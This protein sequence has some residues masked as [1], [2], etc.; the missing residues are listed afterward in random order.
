M[1]T[2]TATEFRPVGP[3]G[4]ILNVV[5]LNLANPWTTIVLPWIVLGLIFLLN[6]ILWWIILSSIAPE[7]RA[8]AQSGFQFSGATTWVFV[9]MMVVA[10]QA[11]NLTFPFALGFGVTRRDFWL[12]SSV[13]FIALAAMYSTAMTI[14]SI[15]EDATN[16]WGFGGRMFTAIYFGENP[17]QRLFIFFVAFLFFFFFGAAI[18]TVYVRWRATGVTFFFVALGALLVAGVAVLTLTRNWQI[19][20]DFFVGAGLV[21]SFAWSLVI[22]AISAVVGF[23]ILR[24][25]T[26]KN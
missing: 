22:T 25:A 20:G 2:M 13:T 24:K 5:K 8:D 12:G 16:G 11:I 3:V 6:L 17:G 21:G 1:T 19:I 4:R 9:Y 26:P 10:I 7:D 23:V 14:L 15:I 18:A